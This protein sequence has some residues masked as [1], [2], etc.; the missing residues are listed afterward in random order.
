MNNLMPDDEQCPQ[1]VSRCIHGYCGR[2]ESTRNLAELL[3][4]I[5]IL[6]KRLQDGG[7]GMADCATS[8]LSEFKRK[9]EERDGDRSRA[10]AD[11]ETKHR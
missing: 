4:L 10:Y 2:R 8:P 9:L 6:S 5:E 7:F 1:C 11:A 3:E